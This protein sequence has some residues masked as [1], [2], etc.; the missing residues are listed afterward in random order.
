MAEKTQKNRRSR[1]AKISEYRLRKLVMCFAKNLTARETAVATKL[2]EPTVRHRFMQIRQLLFDHGP[3]RI[4]LDNVEGRP[5]KDRPAK[6]I[7]ERHYKGVKQEYAHLFE[8]EVLNRIFA[9]KNVN[10]VVR[11]AAWNES[12]MKEVMRYVDYNKLHPKYDLIELLNKPSGAPHDKR[13]KRPFEPLDYETDSIILINEYN[14][15]PDE[16][17]FRVIWELM[18]KFPLRDN[19]GQA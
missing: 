16:A 17:F 10:R 15:A 9:T 12:H 1:N 6:Y 13:E 7:Y 3:M 11:L 14:I 19:K 18:R 5:P 8:I 2:S 4:D